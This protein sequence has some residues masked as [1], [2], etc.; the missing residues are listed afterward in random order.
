MSDKSLQFTHRQIENESPWMISPH[1]GQV[2]VCDGVSKQ[3][4][5]F[6]R[7][8]RW[9]NLRIWSVRSL[10]AE[11]KAWLSA[12]TDFPARHLIQLASPAGFE[13]ALTP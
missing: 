3:L 5:F 12:R 2:H 11:R 7:V 9:K 6:L 8:T 4:Q 1:I 13:P 10:A